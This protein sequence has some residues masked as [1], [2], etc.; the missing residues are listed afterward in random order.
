MSKVSKNFQFAKRPD[1]NK[2]FAEYDTNRCFIPSLELVTILSFILLI[3]A[4]NFYKV[5]RAELL[6]PLKANKRHGRPLVLCGKRG[7]C[8]IIYLERVQHKTGFKEL[9]NAA[10]EETGGQ[11]LDSQ[12][13]RSS[14]TPPPPP[15]KSHRETAVLL[16]ERTC[17]CHCTKKS[18][19]IRGLT[20]HCSSY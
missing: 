15:P 16:D 8:N 9:N 10:A 5:T 11:C 7:V 17:P 4:H 14:Q 2:I 13:A 1:I 12:Q 18:K 20:S 6:Y 3:S 19:P